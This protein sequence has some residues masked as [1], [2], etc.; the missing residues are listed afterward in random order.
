MLLDPRAIHIYTDGSCYNNP[1]GRSG[2]AAIV[3]YPEHLSREDEQILDFGCAESSNNRMELMAC[4]KA[5]LW[6]RE[7][8]P[9]PDVTRVQIITDSLYVAENVA[10]R[11]P[12]WKKNRWRNRYGE[13]KAN[14][15]LWNTLLKLRPKTR[16]RVDFVWRRGKSSEITKRVDKAA[17]AAALRA[18]FDADVGYRPGRVS[19]SMVKDRAPAQRYPADGQ[20]IVIRPYVKKVMHQGELRVSFNIFDEATQRYAGKFFAYAQGNLGAELRTGNGHRVRLNHNP[21]YPEFLERVEAVS[22]PGPRRAKS[23]P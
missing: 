15:D 16:T 12:S 10:F 17:K 11:A 6:I 2:C 23:N 21:N 1:G 13:P 9:W 19:R 7:S 3:H 8:E 20:I 4:I 14:E 18:G 22:L 5:L